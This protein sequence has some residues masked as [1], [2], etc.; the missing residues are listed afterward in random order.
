[1]I[2]GPTVVQIESD[3]MLIDDHADKGSH[4]PQIECS[5]VIETELAPNEPSGKHQLAT[6][7][8]TPQHGKPRVRW[9]EKN[10][11]LLVLGR[12]KTVKKLEQSNS[13]T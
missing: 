2:P 8:P 11:E 10:T 5:D 6:T 4:D 13:S 3:D 1:M 12:L 9:A 7:D